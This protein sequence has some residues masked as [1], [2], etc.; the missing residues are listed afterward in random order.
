M[1]DEIPRETAASPSVQLDTLNYLNLLQQKS[2]QD[3]QSGVK[4]GWTLAGDCDP[5]QSNPVAK[6]ERQ[7]GPEQPAPQSEAV[8]EV[9]QNTGIVNLTP[10]MQEWYLFN[11]AQQ[12]ALQDYEAGRNPGYTPD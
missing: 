10:N 11:L 12:K 5:A 4:N 3:A 6:T 9:R 2:Y 8:D 7:G 1:T